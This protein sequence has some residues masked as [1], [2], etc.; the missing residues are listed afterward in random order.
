MKRVIGF[1]IELTIAGLLF[2]PTGV[3]VWLG[4]YAIVGAAAVLAGLALRGKP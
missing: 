3:I 1:G 4:L 2:G